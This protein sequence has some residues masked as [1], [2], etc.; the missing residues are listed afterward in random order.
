MRRTSV[1]FAIINS[2]YVLLMQAIKSFRMIGVPSKVNSNWQAERTLN[3]L[4]TKVDICTVLEEVF[5]SH[6]ENELCAEV[7]DA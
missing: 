7:G 2:T 1:F 3:P 4:S 6:Q 5:K